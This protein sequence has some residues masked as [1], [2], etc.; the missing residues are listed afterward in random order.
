MISRR[1]L[2]LKFL[3]SLLTVLTGVSVFLLVLK[4]H[5]RNIAGVNLWK[6]A[7]G[8]LVARARNFDMNGNDV[9][10]LLHIQKTGGSKFGA[11]LVKNLDIE[12]PCY[13]SR[14]KA[15]NNKKDAERKTRGRRFC[16]CLRPNSQK[17]WLFSRHHLGWPCGLHADWTELHECVSRYMNKR[18]GKKA[19]RNL[20]YVTI[21]R[22]PVSRFLSEFRFVWNMGDQW[23]ASKN[24]CNRRSPSKK[25][26]PPCFTRENLTGITLDEFIRCPSNLAINRQTRMLADLTLVNCYNTSG[27]S[28]DERGKIMLQSA[29]RNLEEMA[30]FALVEYQRESQ[31][32]F[33]KTFG[34]RFIQPFA[35]SLGSD[36]EAGKISLKLDNTVVQRIADLNEIDGKFYRFAKHLFFRRVQYFRELDNT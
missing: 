15:S 19:K 20:L 2:N 36:T 29:M 9:M 25:E 18:E 26:L 22:E 34:L 7:E 8:Q 12:R 17:I 28:S 24:R 5:A 21:L 6:P 10:V 30:F 23:S 35:Q 4:V 14:K 27:L 3:F 33:E 31:Y 1:G 13:C 32:L 16:R 11:Q